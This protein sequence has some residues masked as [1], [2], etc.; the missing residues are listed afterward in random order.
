L[1]PVVANN[2]FR[3]NAAI[4]RPGTQSDPLL[5]SPPVAFSSS[6]VFRL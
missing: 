5:Y 6:A 2:H 4:A 3:P 1:A